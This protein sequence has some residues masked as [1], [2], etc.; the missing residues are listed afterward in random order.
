MPGMLREYCA[1]TYSVAEAEERPVALKDGRM[2][3][4]QRRSQLW[5][6]SA[7]GRCRRR[8]HREVRRPALS[9]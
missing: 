6:G 3:V 8:I 4:Q 1:Q 7:G 9:W 2:L 5:H